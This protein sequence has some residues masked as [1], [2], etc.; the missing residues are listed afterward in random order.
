MDISGANTLLQEEHATAGI[1]HTFNRLTLKLTGTVA[2][3]NYSD[4][5]DPTLTG[6]VPFAD[7]RDYRETVGTLRSTYEFQSSWA[8]FIESSINERDYDQPITVSGIRRGSA[9]FTAMAGVNLRVGGTLFGEIAGGWGQQQPIDDTLKTISG[10]LLN[11][12][13]I[14]MPSPSTK[15]EFLARSEIDETTLEDS[16]GAIDH[17]FELSLQ[18]AFWRYLVLGVYGS[19]EVADFAEDPQIDRRTKFGATSEYYFNPILSA[20]ARYEHTDFTSTQAASDFVEDEV[21]VGL[22][23]R[24]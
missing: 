8:G 3:Y 23:L 17:F 16:A 11:G 24:R 6:P 19:Y 12:D 9:G 7:I 10:P 14:W 13:L 1:E 2:D 22:K 15:L 21:K 4:V 5:T 18:Q 20:Y